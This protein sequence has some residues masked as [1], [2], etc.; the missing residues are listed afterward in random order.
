MNAYLQPLIQ[1]FEKAANA[2]EA[3]Y[4]EAYMKGHFKFYGMKTAVRREI[5]KE[6]L[7][8]Y[9]L[10]AV[11]TLEALVFDAYQSAYR[12]VHAFAREVSVKLKKQ[13]PEHFIELFEWMI[14]HNS[15]WDS[16]DSISVDLV[17]NYFKKYPAQMQSLTTKWSVHE[18]MWLRRT[19]IIFQVLNKDKTNTALLAANIE[20]NLN[21]KEFFI[22]KAI[23]WALRQ[24]GKTNPNWVVEYVN[25]HDLKP[26]SKREAMRIIIK[27]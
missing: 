10:P 6:F 21:S 9:G 2:E 16:V 1:A 25:S 19:S 24:Y 15:W 18:N 8:E 12:E 22:Q 27:K 17:A 3:A 7:K 23:G 13:W 5:Q 26:L 20:P 11:E 4:M 14:V